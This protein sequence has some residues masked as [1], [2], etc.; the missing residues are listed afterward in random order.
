MATHSSIFAWRI[1]L[2]SQSPWSCKESDTTGQL[3]TQHY[4]Y[5]IDFKNKDLLYSTE[6]YAQYLVY[7]YLLYT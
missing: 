7:I 6:N 4:I 2:E 1:P 5:K 3:I